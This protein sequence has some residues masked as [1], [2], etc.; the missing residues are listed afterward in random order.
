MKSLCQQ[1]NLISNRRKLKNIIN[2]AVPEK[3][4]ELKMLFRNFLTEYKHHKLVLILDSLENLYPQD[5]AYK[6]DWLP[7][8]LSSNCRLILSVTAESDEL[9]RRLKRKY[10][11]DSS[12]ITIN[13]LNKEQIELMVQKKLRLNNYR[14][15][16]NQLDFIR[17]FL[18]KNKT[19]YPLHF[20]MLSEQFLKWR[21]SYTVSECILKETLSLSVQYFLKNLETRFN[22]T[23]VKFILCKSRLILSSSL[24]TIFE[25]TSSS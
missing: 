7:K 5:N 13:G 24:K 23:L 22:K 4:V 25:R 1:L 15:E 2:T 3:L 20:K 19:I 10:I 8:Y 14:L 11:N 17:T 6:L 9:I 18:D 21:S 12:F 16:N